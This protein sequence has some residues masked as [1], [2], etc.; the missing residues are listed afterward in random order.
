MK[1]SFTCI[2]LLFFAFPT[3]VAFAGDWS[4]SMGGQVTYAQVDGF[5]QTPRGGQI[6]STSLKRP[7]FDEIGIKNH[8]NFQLTAQVNYDSFL[9]AFHFI[10]SHLNGDTQLSSN[11]ITH[12]ILLSA[13][14]YF[15]AKVNDELYNL[16]FG[17]VFELCSRW[18]LTPK[19]KV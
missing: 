15:K 17:Y 8:T 12:N 16:Q 6:G 7:S 13:G 10:P 19:L 4:F 18:H 3:G 14:T 5:Q 1:H 2:Y 9:M 11:L